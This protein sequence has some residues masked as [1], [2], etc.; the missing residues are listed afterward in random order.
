MT[1]NRQTMEEFVERAQDADFVLI[2]APDGNASVYNCASPE[3]R[4]TAVLRQVADNMD[5]LVGENACGHCGS[6]FTGGGAC[7]NVNCCEYGRMQ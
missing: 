2:L 3:D 1:M 6:M 4:V 5:S 7:E